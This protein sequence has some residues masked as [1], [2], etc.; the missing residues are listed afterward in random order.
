M[1]FVAFHRRRPIADIVSIISYR[2]VITALFEQHRHVITELSTIGLTSKQI[3]NK[4]LL[5]GTVQMSFPSRFTRMSKRFGLILH[6]F[7]VERT[8]QSIPQGQHI[9]EFS[10]LNRR[11]YGTGESALG[12][13]YL[14]FEGSFLCFGVRL[15]L[16]QLT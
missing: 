4:G 11:C 1:I 6:A 9:R 15:S 3:I 5:V 10:G 8:R 2:Q 14:F 16:L 7:T 12:I 13:S